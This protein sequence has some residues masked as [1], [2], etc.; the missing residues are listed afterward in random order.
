MNCKLNQNQKNEPSIKK[1]IALVSV[2]IKGGNN[3]LLYILYR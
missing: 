2:L 3:C 1:K